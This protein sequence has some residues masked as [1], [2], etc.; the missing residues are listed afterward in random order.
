MNQ[1]GNV[2]TKALMLAIFLGMALYITLDIMLAEGRSLGRLYLYMAIAAFLC[3]AVASR[4]AF[5]V[6]LIT[7]GYIDFFKRLMAVFGRPSPTDLY[8][9]LG[10]PP[11]LI[12]GAV[13]NLLIQFLMGRRQFRSVHFWSLL[14]S[15]A[16]MALSLAQGLS[17]GSFRG[18]GDAVNQSAYAFLFFL[19]PELLPNV[20]D[21]KKIFKWMI[22][23]FL[24]VALY[25]LRHH[26]YGLA[27]FEYDYLMSG[28]SI[29]SRI[30]IENG[31]ALRGFSTMA[32][33][34][35]VAVLLSIMM[36]VVLVPLKAEGQKTGL[37]EWIFR[38]VIFLVLAY[39]S[40]ATVS[41][42]GWV[43]GAAAFAA[44][45][46]LKTPARAIIGYASGAIFCLGIM[47]AA[48]TMLKEGTMDWL[49]S[50]L[51]KLVSGTNNAYAERA[52]VLGTMNARLEGWQN[53][54]TNPKV[55]TPFGMKQEGGQFQ[56]GD[57]DYYG[58]DFIVAFLVKYGYIA[59]SIAVCVGLIFL[60]QL[61]RVYFSSP[62]GSLERQVC[63]LALAVS[64]G[65]FVGGLGNGAQLW[66][67][68]QNFYFYLSL[69]VV[70][71]T[72]VNNW[73]AKRALVPA[74]DAPLVAPMELQSDTTGN[75]RTRLSSKRRKIP[76][77][78][79]AAKPTS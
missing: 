16:L 27:N 14:A 25:M 26:F 3:G 41:R 54:T 12:A 60:I 66:V 40:W 18:L 73:K 1:I 4:S 39:G 72:Y 48:P 24:G 37:F 55:W 5:F 74:L 9:I 36:L 50:E 19:I 63:R 70:Y 46:F 13:V 75:S 68:P 30:L 35:V 61:N 65:I 47:F 10:I 33:A 57:E 7:T 28:L 44:F 8:Y 11:L 6:C 45:F 77:G 29:E 31:D 67:Y 2:I 23:I 69:A 78:S 43:C 76:F 56:H 71:T 64:A 21:R 53:L 79:N 32:G 59:L 42:G 51:S 62:I 49:E 17:G 34:G 58:H 15:I 22:P 20:E 52:I 38:G